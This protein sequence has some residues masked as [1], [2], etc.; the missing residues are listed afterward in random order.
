MSNFGIKRSTFP[1][2]SNIWTVN[3]KNQT[4]QK[5][6]YNQKEK[7]MIMPSITALS[8]SQSFSITGKYSSKK[9]FEIVLDL[10]NI[11]IEDIIPKIPSF[12]LN[13]IANIFSKISRSPKDNQLKLKLKFQI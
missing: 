6:I 10:K 3:P 4:I 13:G 12:S 7:I 8:E 11:T 9:D 1:I 5:I 2:G